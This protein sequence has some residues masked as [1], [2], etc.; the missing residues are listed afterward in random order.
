MTDVATALRVGRKFTGT[1]VASHE[2]GKVFE[3]R[4]MPSWFAWLFVASGAG[5]SLIVVPLAA[6]GAW[7]DD[8]TGGI[9]LGVFCFF[10][11]LIG[12]VSWV[13]AI[14]NRVRFVLGESARGK[15]AEVAWGAI[16][17]ARAHFFL[18]QQ[19]S[20]RRV[21]IYSTLIV[22]VVQRPFEGA[23]LECLD[24]YRGVVGSHL[25]R[26]RVEAL[27]VGVNDALRQLG[28]DWSDEAE[29]LYEREHPA[30]TPESQLPVGY[31]AVSK[32]MGY[33]MDAHNEQM[34][35]FAAQLGLQYAP[36]DTN[37]VPAVFGTLGAT[38]LRIEW[39]AMT[40]F[41]QKTRIRATFSS[42]LGLGLSIRRGTG[43]ATGDATF[44][45][46]F[47]AT[48]RDPEA[49]R[50]MLDDEVRQQLLAAQGSGAQVELDDEGVTYLL[51]GAVKDAPI[52]GPI[53]Q[54]LVGV[55]QAFESRRG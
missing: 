17:G 53:V 35:A 20:G 49:F 29:A 48:A 54:H 52:I 16:L 32:A 2:P 42:P 24:L 36:V 4:T 33:D 10:A 30:P 50:R 11:W 3:L 34:H 37:G 7:S 39:Q 51:G 25:A 6:L 8:P 22:S 27:A 9:S 45:G 38:A 41:D 21:Y 5:L 19:G 40:V 46:W 15:G 31:G 43:S 1:W 26:G 12:G 47:E 14:R 44:D 13:L 18:D 55:V 28:L 23:E